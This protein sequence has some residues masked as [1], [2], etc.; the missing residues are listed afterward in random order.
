ML[1]FA[2]SGFVVKPLQL[3]GECSFFFLGYQFIISDIFWFGC[4]CSL[5]V[6]QNST[7][8]FGPTES[9][10]GLTSVETVAPVTE[11]SS[12]LF[13]LPLLC[14]SYSWSDYKS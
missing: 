3:K 13:S 11:G 14:C 5:I 2:V 10:Q 6:S 4:V 12:L 7:T 1:P 8:G 9:R